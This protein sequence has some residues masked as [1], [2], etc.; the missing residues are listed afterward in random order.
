MI[1]ECHSVL[2]QDYCILLQIQLPPIETVLFRLLSAA[3]MLHKSASMGGLPGAGRRSPRR[4]EDSAH[5][6]KSR[7]AKG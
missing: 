3:D 6:P 2:Q 1:L 4:L 7:G 5:N